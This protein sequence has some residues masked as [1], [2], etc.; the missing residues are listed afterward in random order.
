MLRTYLITSAFRNNI[1][2]LYA[3]C[4]TL[5]IS[6]CI[7]DIAD[8]AD[9]EP[10]QKLNCRQAAGYV[11]VKISDFPKDRFSK[12]RMIREGAPTTMDYVKKRASIVYNDKGYIARAYCG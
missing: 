3:V 6:G 10:P 5:L 12:I 2:V 11:G 8:H 1:S 4:I 9:F 7:E